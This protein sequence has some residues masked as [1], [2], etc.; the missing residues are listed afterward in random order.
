M[1][2]KP[3]TSTIS[4]DFRISVDFCIYGY[5]LRII[6]TYLRGDHAKEG[7]TDLTETPLDPAF[8]TI[9]TGDYNMHHK[10]WAH[11][12]YSIASTPRDT[13]HFAEWIIANKIEVMN[14]K[15]VITR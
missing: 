5:N 13:A 14:R 3:T 2:Y 12:D 4:V 15:N 8:P 7:L 1:A 6:N 9:F 11:E 10:L